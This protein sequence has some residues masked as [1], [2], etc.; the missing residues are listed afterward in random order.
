METIVI[1]KADFSMNGNSLIGEFD[2]V[3]TGAEGKVNRGAGMK[4]IM[5]ARLTYQEEG[6]D[7]CSVL[8]RIGPVHLFVSIFP[9]L[10]SFRCFLFHLL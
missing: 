6:L 1:Y 10:C 3:E 7:G 4:L 9:I 2:L 5:T 8:K